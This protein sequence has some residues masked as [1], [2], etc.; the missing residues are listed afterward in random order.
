MF[1]PTLQN[2][3]LELVLLVGSGIHKI[4]EEKKIK[5]IEAAFAE[6]TYKLAGSIGPLS[7]LLLVCF[8]FTP[9]KQLNHCTA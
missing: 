9:S 2:G 3:E 7:A 8:C 1:F 4:E 6:E 5:K